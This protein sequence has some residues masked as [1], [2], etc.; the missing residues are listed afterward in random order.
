MRP[1]SFAAWITLLFLTTLAVWGCSRG[2]DLDLLTVLDITPRELD[3]GD[4]IE[5]I[6]VDFPE[7]KPAEIYFE[8]DL[9]RPGR[10]VEKSVA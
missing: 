10:P 7:G 1:K 2:H 6:G 5:I 8:G 3:L 4:R 9:Y